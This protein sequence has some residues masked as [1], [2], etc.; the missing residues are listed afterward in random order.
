MLCKESGL[1]F[2]VLLFFFYKCMYDYLERNV[3]WKC[4]IIYVRN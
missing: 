3:N 2:I 4:K 1:I